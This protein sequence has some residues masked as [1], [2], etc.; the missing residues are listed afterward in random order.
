MWGEYSKMKK[1]IIV[2]T[3]AAISS[4]IAFSLFFASRMSKLSE[5]DLFD[6]EQDDF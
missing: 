4:I 5:L 6:I 3:L 2:L 1:K